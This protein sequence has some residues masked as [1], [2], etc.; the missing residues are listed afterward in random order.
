MKN[1]TFYSNLGMDSNPSTI[2]KILV[3]GLIAL[4]VLTFLVIG[5]SYLESITGTANGKNIPWV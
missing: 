1:V 5:Y 2:Q 3:F 4:A